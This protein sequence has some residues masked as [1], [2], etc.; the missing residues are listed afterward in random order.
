MQQTDE[1]TGFLYQDGHNMSDRETASAR[2]EGEEKIRIFICDIDTQ[3]GE[4]L[5]GYAR[6]L[7]HLQFY[8]NK[9]GTFSKG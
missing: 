1:M 5:P 4:R 2:K 9:A 3:A 7:P 8:Q 6:G